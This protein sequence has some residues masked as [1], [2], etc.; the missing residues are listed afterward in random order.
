MSSL[1]STDNKGKV[2][3]HA[4]AMATN[5][6]GICTHFEA[7]LIA[8]VNAIDGYTPS[9]EASHNDL[10]LLASISSEHRTA[11]ICD[12]TKAGLLGW[13]Q[14]SCPLALTHQVCYR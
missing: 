4:D 6:H 10:L 9:G 14:L 8:M 12:E 13:R 11:I 5:V 3:V 2:T 7:F 1:W